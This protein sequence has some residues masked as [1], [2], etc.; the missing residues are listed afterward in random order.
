M[1]K[2]CISALT[3]YVISLSTSTSTS[4]STPIKIQK[5]R[6]T[7]TDDEKLEKMDIATIEKFLRKNKLKKIN[8]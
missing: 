2:D 7:E 3:D 6:Y 5:I 1:N 8:K 4:T